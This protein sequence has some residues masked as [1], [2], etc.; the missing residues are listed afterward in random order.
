MNRPPENPPRTSAIVASLRNSQLA[1]GW[2]LFASVWAAAECFGMA[3][4]LLRTAQPGMGAI[5]LPWTMIMAAISRGVA[6][7]FLLENLRRLLFAT[8]QPK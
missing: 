3:A 8:C 5:W 1:I 4:A 7:G 2:L 6:L